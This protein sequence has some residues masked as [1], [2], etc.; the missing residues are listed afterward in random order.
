[1]PMPRSFGSS[2][3][4]LR[5]FDEDLPVGDIEKTGDAIEQGRLAAAGRT[6]KHEELTVMNVEVERVENVNAHQS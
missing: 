6:E 2:Q 4:T 5:P 1:M 3:V